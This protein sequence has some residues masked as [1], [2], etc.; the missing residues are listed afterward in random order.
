MD[1]PRRMDKIMRFSYL[2][3][4]ADIN[5]E[6]LKY[7]GIKKTKYMANC[8]LCAG[9]TRWFDNYTGRYVCSVECMEHIRNGYGKP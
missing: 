3:P 2:Y 5:F 7:S 8:Y 6:I 1:L 9:K 4:K